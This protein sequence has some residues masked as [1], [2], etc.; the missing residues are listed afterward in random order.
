MGCICCGRQEAD[1][2]LPSHMGNLRACHPCVYRHGAENL[3]KEAD[4][5][6]VDWYMGKPHQPVCLVCGT[7]MIIAPDGSRPVWCEPCE[8]KRVAHTHASAKRG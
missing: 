4:R 3:A 1:N 5:L 7:P 2:K 6:L 8:A